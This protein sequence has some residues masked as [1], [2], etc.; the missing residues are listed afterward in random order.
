LGTSGR[1][2]EESKGTASFDEEHGSIEEE[3]GY[4]QMLGV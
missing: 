2:P 3:R 4:F 1:T